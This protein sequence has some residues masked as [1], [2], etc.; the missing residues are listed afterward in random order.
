MVTNWAQFENRTNNFR[1]HYFCA[2]IWGSVGIFRGTCVAF[3]VF[4]GGVGG[5]SWVFLVVVAIVILLFL[6]YFGV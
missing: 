5:G 6:F 3:L 1:K 4:L 2:G